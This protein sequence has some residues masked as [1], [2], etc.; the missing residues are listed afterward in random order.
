MWN[1][2]LQ[3]TLFHVYL[4]KVGVAGTELSP[5]QKTRIA[6][7]KALLRNPRILLL[8][9]ATSS[10]DYESEQALNKIMLRRTTIVTA[11]KLSDVCNADRIN[12]S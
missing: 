10:L 7:A 4:I 2:H 1:N 5:S 11:R 12:F 8:D 3:M 9:D 6:I